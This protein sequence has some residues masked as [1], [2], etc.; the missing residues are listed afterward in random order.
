MFEVHLFFYCNYSYKSRMDL[1]DYKV[2][3]QKRKTTELV[4][5]KTLGLVAH[6]DKD[7]KEE[8]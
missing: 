6:S 4:A 2:S 8:I 7:D 5:V 1:E 3:M